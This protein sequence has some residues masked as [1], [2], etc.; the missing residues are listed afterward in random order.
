MLFHVDFVIVLQYSVWFVSLI[1]NE[2]N[3]NYLSDICIKYLILILLGFWIFVHS[4]IYLEAETKFIHFYSRRFVRNSELFLEMENAFL[5]IPIRRLGFK[6]LVIYL[7]LRFKTA[8]SIIIM[9]IVKLEPMSNFFEWGQLWCSGI[10]YIRTCTR[11]VV[12]S[13]P[14]RE[15]EIFTISLSE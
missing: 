8:F 15:S 13:I 11:L 10:K 12:G 6:W 5:Y 1:F 4:H 3:R 9:L 14:T 2:I 7:S